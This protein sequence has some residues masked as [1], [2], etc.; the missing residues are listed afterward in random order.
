MKLDLFKPQWLDLVF[1]GRNKKYGAY[2]LRKENPKTSLR[3]LLIGGVIFALAVSSPTI[4][5]M[6]PKGD[7]AKNSLDEKVVLVN[8]EKP[9]ENIPPPPPEKKTGTAKTK[10]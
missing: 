2:E 3:A 9:K 8:M 5:D 1:E 7:D 4:I 10:N 6:I